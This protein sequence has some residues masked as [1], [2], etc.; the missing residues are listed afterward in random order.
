MSSSRYRLGETEAI[1]KTKKKKKR[2]KDKVVDALR[3][4]HEKEL[5]GELDKLD[6]HL[7]D[8]ACRITRSGDRSKKLIVIQ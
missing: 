1:V 8:G 4:I 7:K 3:V 6:I 5:E 2:K